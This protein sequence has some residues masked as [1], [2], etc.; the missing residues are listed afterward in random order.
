MWEECLV[1]AFD[2][3]QATSS[4]QLQRLHSVL[5]HHHTAGSRATWFDGTF[6]LMYRGLEPAIMDIDTNPLVN[7]M[8]SSCSS[9]SVSKYFVH[10]T[11]LVI[12]LGFEP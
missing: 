4:Y 11:S 6:G 12:R 8:P 1:L 9:F 10:H 7:T 2:P 5:G 3:S